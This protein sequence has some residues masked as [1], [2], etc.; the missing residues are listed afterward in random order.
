MPAHGEI[1]FKQL[2]SYSSFLNSFKKRGQ[3]K[4]RA[5]EKV[6]EKQPE[7]KEKATEEIEELIEHSEKP[8]FELSTIFPL[9]L[10]PDKLTIDIN[11]INLLSS[12]FFAS[13]RVHSVMIKDVGDVFIDTDL[14]F[15]KLTIIDKGFT[16]NSISLKYLK[17]KDASKARRIVQGLVVAN[18]Q[19]IDLSQF[20][21][22]DLA[23][24]LEELGK[25]K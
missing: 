19:K 17:K 9:D 21:P 20:T 6:Q 7:S 25:I 1:T 4:I 16:E 13:G 11:K 8:I 18:E 24:K 22:E 14:F 3:E 2:K 12:E 23:T 5:E 15:A 10:F